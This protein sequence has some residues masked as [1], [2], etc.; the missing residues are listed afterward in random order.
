VLLDQRDQLQSFGSRRVASLVRAH[1]GFTILL[2]VGLLAR[3]LCALAY[4][5]ALMYADSSGYLRLAH[6]GSVVGFVPDR[7]SG[8]PLLI[9]LLTLPG[10]RTAIVIIAQHLAGL[11]IGPLVYALVL[12]AGGRRSL[13]LGAA[14]IVLLDG[15]LILLE[16]Y[17]MPETFT[18]LFLTLSAWFALTASSSDS[19]GRRPTA[20]LAAS[21]ALL[22]VAGTI[23]TAALFA[24]PIW[25]IYV[26]GIRIRL[27]SIAI[28]GAALLAPLLAYAAL[29][30]AAGYGSALN[31]SA[32]WFLYG[33]VAGF[34]DCA[35]A[36]IPKDA[37]DLCPP[38]A[39]RGW[40]P[41]HYIW[42]RSVATERFPGGPPTHN[43]RANTQLGGFAFAVIRDQ[44]VTYAWTVTKD[45][46]RVF[47]TDGGT[48]ASD[49]LSYAPHDPNVAQSIF[50]A[51][52]YVTVPGWLTMLLLLSSIAAVA[53][54]RRQHTW[55]IVLLSGSA[56][57]ITAGAVATVQTDYRYLLSALPLLACGGALAL[58]DLLGS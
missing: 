54:H 22:A 51:Y 48:Q 6:T 24:I 41:S 37:R 43:D 5:P 11:I 44:P 36:D 56:L 31:T 18:A 49:L 40:S 19:R 26:F 57:A 30:S 32:G 16:Q 28:A 35:D 46:G 3:I 39:E 8:Y 10:H 53:R 17:V 38:N 12:R 14:A 50:R 2:G 58:D 29:Q 33:R 21:A 34:A 47:L 7:P 42:G 52:R 15:D 13:A 1:R 4:W 9:H 45:V 20:H 55:D 23:R 25:L 27:R